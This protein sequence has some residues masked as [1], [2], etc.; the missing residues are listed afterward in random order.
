MCFRA[1]WARR[2]GRWIAGCRFT[3]RVMGGFWRVLA[4]SGW[5]LASSGWVLE[6]KN[7]TSKIIEIHCKRPG[8]GFRRLQDGAKM[9]PKNALVRSVKILRIHC[10]KQGLGR[11]SV[12][13][14]ID[15]FWKV[16]FFSK[17]TFFH[18]LWF[19]PNGS[20]N[21]EVYGLFFLVFLAQN[22]SVFSD[23]VLVL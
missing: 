4:G 22:L 1:L 8:F 23:L 6:L 7:D 15:N 10:K 20:S 21:C 18:N 16:W 19:C 12:I 11:M 2:G 13:Q 14:K 5:V 17:N 3:V 9:D